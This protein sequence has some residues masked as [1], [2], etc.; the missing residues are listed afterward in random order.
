MGGGHHGEQSL[1]PALRPRPVEIQDRCTRNGQ[2]AGSGA[3]A[4]YRIHFVANCIDAV[5][6]AHAANSWDN[7]QVRGGSAGLRRF[8]RFSPAAILTKPLPEKID[9]QLAGQGAVKAGRAR[10]GSQG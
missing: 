1:T 6:E 8:R 10:R 7:S 5:V 4:M 9:W 2:F 3:Y